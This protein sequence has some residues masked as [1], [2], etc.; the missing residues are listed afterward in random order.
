MLFF[1]R[2]SISFKIDR[3]YPASSLILIQRVCLAVLVLTFSQLCQSLEEGGLQQGKLQSLN[4]GRRSR[5]HPKINKDFQ[6]VV[7]EFNKQDDCWESG[8][9]NVDLSVSDERQSI[10][11]RFNLLKFVF[12]IAILYKKKMD[13]IVQRIFFS[14]SYVLRCNSDAC[15]PVS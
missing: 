2:R 11:I 12:Q 10:G 4:M 15:M 8:P 3:D 7:G 14:E 13:T 1:K 9:D 5:G 6:T